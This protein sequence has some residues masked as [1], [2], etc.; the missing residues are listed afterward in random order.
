MVVL[1]LW[2]AA[3]GILMTC[4]VVVVLICVPTAWLWWGASDDE[5]DVVME[6]IQIQEALLQSFAHGKSTGL[7]IDLTGEEVAVLLHVAEP[8]KQPPSER[9]ADFQRLHVAY[10]FVSFPLMRALLS[11]YHGAAEL[12]RVLKLDFV[13]DL[14][15]WQEP[16]AWEE[17]A[18]GS[19]D[20]IA[21]L[22]QRFSRIV[23]DNVAID[24]KSDEARIVELTGLGK[25]LGRGEWYGRN[26][27]CSDS[28]LQVLAWHDV[29]PRCLR[30]ERPRR[31]KA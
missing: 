24:A 5:P 21:S 11:K 16:G 3:V 9:D 13:R 20:E 19:D 4:F 7:E 31:Q 14:H 25:R 29:L 26:E 23:L 12:D 18:D 8:L 10:P 6:E 22:V 17:P 27:C 1:I 28:L 15:L 30:P 2:R